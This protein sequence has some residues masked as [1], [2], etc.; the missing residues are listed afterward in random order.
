MI[1]LAQMLESLLKGPWA[2]YQTL[3]KFGDQVRK[4]HLLKRRQIRLNIDWMRSV[5]HE[6]EGIRLEV[7]LPS[8]LLISPLSLESSMKSLKLFEPLFSFVK[9]G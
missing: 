6:E 9:W 5:L 2:L 1:A 8:F 4:S 3:P 7:R